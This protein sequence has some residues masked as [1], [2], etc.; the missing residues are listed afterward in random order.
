MYTYHGNKNQMVPISFSIV[1]SIIIR[2]NTEVEEACNNDVAENVFASMQIL[3]A[4]DKKNPDYQYQK[5]VGQNAVYI[6]TSNFK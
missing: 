1:E 3:C 5:L 2:L 6:V 4:Q